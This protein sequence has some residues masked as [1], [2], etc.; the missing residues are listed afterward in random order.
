MLNNSGTMKGKY[1]GRINKN[2]GNVYQ[3]CFSLLLYN[4]KIEAKQN[5][6]ICIS[7]L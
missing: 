7:H 6:Q 5:K 2:K 4:M 3:Y 1:T